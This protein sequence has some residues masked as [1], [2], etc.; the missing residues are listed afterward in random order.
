MSP[1]GE[2]Q[3]PETGPAPSFTEVLSQQARSAP[4]EPERGGSVT[5]GHSTSAKE[6]E[7][8]RHLP[9][10]ETTGPADAAQA[11]LDLPVGEL[12]TA[13][14]PS[15]RAQASAA[16]VGEPTVRGT[17]DTPTSGGLPLPRPEPLAAESHSLVPL[18]ASTS[19]LSDAADVV[20]ADPGHVDQPPTEMPTATALVA[21]SVD[22]SDGQA[23]STPATTGRPAAPV[24]TRQI[25]PAA[26]GGPLMAGA[27]RSEGPASP[28]VSP[29]TES[30]SVRLVPPS[31]DRPT[32]PAAPS[33]HVL[34][35]GSGDP[36]GS[37][38]TGP[39]T[40]SGG[41]PTPLSAFSSSEQSSGSLDVDGLS[42]SISR[43]L[44]DG[45]GTYTVSVAMH[46]SDLG[47][48]RA[49]MSLDGNDLQVLITPQTRTGHEALTNAADALKN[50]LASAG[51]NVNVTLR[52]PGSSS[53]GEDHVEVD[54]TSSRSADLE[55]ETAPRA[56]VP[57]LVAGQIHLVL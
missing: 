26:P 12:P 38:M 2:T 18:S 52:D 22:P 11:S 55:N 36:H 17:S 30:P 3:S 25:R 44:S 40:R 37:I 5:G 16:A 14:V 28:H 33:S 32:Q 49:V 31:A 4:R 9:R 7:N 53:G 45:N 43:P 21:A 57:V 10:E 6:R 54:Q 23:S 27:D 19:V 56:Q 41:D 13:G 39:V 51:L 35:E 34:N 1:T 46:P 24:A 29:A 47:H 50:Q 20:A 42:G 48:L 8:P 15:G